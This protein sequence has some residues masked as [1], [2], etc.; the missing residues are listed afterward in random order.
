M[1]I[2]NYKREKTPKYWGNQSE[3]AKNNVDRA[4]VNLVSKENYELISHD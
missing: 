4:F 2:N 3:K 1:S